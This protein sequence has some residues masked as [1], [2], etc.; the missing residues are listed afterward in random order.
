MRALVAAMPQ[1]IGRP[2]AGLGGRHGRA[3]RRP[4]LSDLVSHG[5]PSTHNAVPAGPLSW[6]R[7]SRRPPLRALS[8]SSGPFQVEFLRQCRAACPIAARIPR[9]LA[10][11]SILRVPTTHGLRAIAIATMVAIGGITAVASPASA[12]TD[13]PNTGARVARIA[14]DQRGDQYAYGGIGPS[15]FDCSGLVLYAYRKAGVGSRIGGGH[16]A[17]GMYLWGKSHGLTSRSNPRV[18]DVVIYGRGSHAGDLHREGPCRPCPQQARRHRRYEPARPHDAV[19]HVHPHADP[20]RLNRGPWYTLV[21]SSSKTNQHNSLRSRWSSSTSS[22]ISAGSWARCH[23]HSRRPAS[24][25][26][27][28]GDCRAGG[29]DRIGRGTQLVGR[30]MAHRRGL[31]GRVCGMPSLPRAGLWPRRLHG[32][33]PCGQLPT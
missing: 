33:P 7:P 2:F 19:H 9:V 4:W 16:S 17:R 21:F 15:R 5:V 11:R 30:H 23:W 3:W 6:S 14:L 26:S 22:R 12:A 28:S 27:P 32:R 20:A 18:G 10:E 8:R 24:R 25:S 29:P 31:A 1:P 13:V